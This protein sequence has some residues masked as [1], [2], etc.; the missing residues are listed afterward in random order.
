MREK[1]KVLCFILC[2]K[3]IS[4][5]MKNTAHRSLY[6]PVQVSMYIN[7]CCCILHYSHFIKLR[8]YTCITICLAPWIS[9]TTHVQLIKQEFYLCQ[10]KHLDVAVRSYYNPCQQRLESQQMVLCCR[11]Y[12]IVPGRTSKQ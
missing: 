10:I 5:A 7:N 8:K 1:R 9:M 3:H 6:L 12:L 11:I 4:T 2:V